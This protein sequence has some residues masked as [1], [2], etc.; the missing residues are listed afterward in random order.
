MTDLYSR[1]QRVIARAQQLRFHPLAAE[2][3]EG[4]T[5]VEPGGRRLID[6]SAG[7][8]VAGLGYGH[9]E[10]IR[11]VTEAVTTMP[12]VSILSGTHRYAVELAE[13]LLEL[14]PTAGDDRCVYIGLTG[15][16]ANTAVWRAIRGWSSRPKVVAFEHSYHGGL[17]SAQ[18]ISGIF[19]GTDVVPDPELVLVPY[20]NLTALEQAL[21]GDDVAAVFLEPILSDGGLIIPAPG[22]L[23]GVGELCT[24][25]GSL[26]VVDE[27]KVGLART[28]R[29]H[30]FQAEDVVPDIVTLGKSLGGGVPVSAVIGPTEILGNE[31]ATSLLTM[32]GNPISCAAALAVLSTLEAEDYVGQSAALGE[33]LA[34]LLSDLSERHEAIADV[35]NR[36]LVGGIELAAIPGESAAGVCAKTVYRAWQLGVVVYSVGV[37]SNV[38]EL[39]PPLV[40]TA[41]EL[42]RSF[43][44]LSQALSDVTSGRVTDEDVAAFAGWA[45]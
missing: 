7:W 24:R 38:I 1:D 29:F 42:T 20:D 45:T 8:S 36:G 10:V 40:I 11:A 3:G 16:D 13:R 9:P 14:T 6:L 27:V 30:A 21:V 19:A 37:D 5:L 12:G 22:F 15:S 23:A 26:L 25:Y 33:H 35:R 32:A 28:G 41:D 34:M 39:T 18:T 43:T 44:I 17:G 4:A 31:A 2:R